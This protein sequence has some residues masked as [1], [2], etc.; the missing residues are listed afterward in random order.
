MGRVREKGGADTEKLGAGL[1]GPW[2]DWGQQT[3]MRSI[4]GPI[5]PAVCA[6][7]PSNPP[8]GTGETSPRACSAHPLGSRGRGLPR[9][10]EGTSQQAG[11]SIQAFCYHS[12]QEYNP[13][14]SQI[15][16]RGWVQGRDYP[17]TREALTVTGIGLVPIL[18]D[19]SVQLL[20]G[21]AHTFTLTKKQQKDALI[22]MS[23][24]E[25]LSSPGSGC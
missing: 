23:R 7:G 11:E 2:L 14:S 1:W 25:E 9:V 3:W 10:S 16:S 12:E 5:L 6:P 18:Q 21:T 13:P 19:G 24:P 8:Q 22:Q 15:L 17:P 20:T 4:K